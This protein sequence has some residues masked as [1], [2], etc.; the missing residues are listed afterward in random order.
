MDILL[1]IV[2]LEET[3]YHELLPI[4]KDSNLDDKVKWEIIDILETAVEQT[5]QAK[6]MGWL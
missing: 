2:Q 3:R 5:K 4:L 6:N 1:A